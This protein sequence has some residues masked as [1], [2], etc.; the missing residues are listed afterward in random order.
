MLSIMG[1]NENWMN[2]KDKV[3]EVQ[4]LCKLSIGHERRK[5]SKRITKE[6]ELTIVKMVKELEMSRFDVANDFSISKS[7]VDNILK[8]YNVKE[9][10]TKRELET[11]NRRKELARRYYDSLKRGIP[12][13]NVINDYH[14]NYNTVKKYINKY[15][16]EE[17]RL[18]LW[19]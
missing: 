17:E 16:S 1:A 7:S 15:I 18:E 11:E 14:T 19:T 10:K 5:R 13:K 2:D 4:R 3:E 8:K 9:N 6:Q 12:M